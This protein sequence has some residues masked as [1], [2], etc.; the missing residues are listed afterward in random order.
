[1]ISIYSWRSI[2]DCPLSRTE[3]IFAFGKC[4]SAR[5]EN[6]CSLSF[7]HGLS[8][9]FFN[10]KVGVGNLTLWPML[11]LLRIWVRNKTF[12]SRSKPNSVTTVKHSHQKYS[13]FLEIGSAYLFFS[14]RENVKRGPLWKRDF[15]I[16]NF[17][18][19]G[20]YCTIGNA[21]WLK[22]FETDG[23]HR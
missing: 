23:L 12:Q 8:R 7:H 16:K 3:T 11:Q 2:F 17:G 18:S 13:H 22:A 1:M 19:V 20:M 21:K 4:G 9:C 10:F 14:K 5:A 15:W 6:S